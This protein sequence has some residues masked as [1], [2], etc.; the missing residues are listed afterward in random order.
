MIQLFKKN[1]IKHTN[2]RIV[3]NNFKIYSVPTTF[4]KRGKYLKLLK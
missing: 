4:K 2:I 3:T 1:V